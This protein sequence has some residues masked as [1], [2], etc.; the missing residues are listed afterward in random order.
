MAKDMFKQIGSF[1][2]Y[3]NQLHADY[4]ILNNRTRMKDCIIVDDKIEFIPTENFTSDAPY[5]IKESLKEIYNL[6]IDEKKEKSVEIIKKICSEKEIILIELKEPLL[7]IKISTTHMKHYN[8]YHIYYNETKNGI[9]LD[10]FELAH[11][12]N[13]GASVYSTFRLIEYC[14]QHL[15]PSI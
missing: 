9:S 10:N 15:I 14:N 1:Y 4:L 12:W 11:Q 2:L 6:N 13:I 7:F 5:Y 8:G 3:D